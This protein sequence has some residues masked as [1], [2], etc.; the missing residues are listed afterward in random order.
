LN[1]ANNPHI[2]HPVLSQSLGFDAD[3]R[4]GIHS[5][6][7]GGL[8]TIF[9]AAVLLVA[10]RGK[11]FLHHAYG[12]LDPDARQTPTQTASLFDLASVTKLF[13]ATAFMTLGEAGRVAL[14]TP[15]AD[16][17]SGFSKVGVI[18]ATEDPISK[19]AVPANLQLAGQEVDARQVTFWHLLTHTSG[20]AAWRSL[21]RENGETGADVSLPQHVSAERRSRRVAAIHGRYGFAYPPGKRMF[22]SDFGVIL[23]GEAVAQLAGTSLDAYVRQP[24]SMRKRLSIVW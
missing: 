1:R 13:T 19:A 5:I 21:Y 7:R 12:C 24:A 2:L 16:L 3:G 22:Y 9:P 8:G 11:V 15:V 18:G 14:E 20:L 10:R 4:Q 23:L 6:K 17:L